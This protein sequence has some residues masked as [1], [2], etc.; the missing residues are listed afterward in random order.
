[1]SQ[2]TEQRTT[3]GRA[4]K[5]KTFLFMIAFLA[6]GIWGAWDAMRVYPKRGRIYSEFML[7]NYL[8][9]A[10]AQ[11]KL[12]SA[13]VEDPAG[14]LRALSESDARSPLEEA[15]YQWLSAL[16]RVANLPAI[17]RENKK[18]LAARARGAL[19]PATPTMFSDPSAKLKEIAQLNATRNQPAPLNDYDIPLQYAFMFAGAAGFVAMVVF[20]VRVKSKTYRYDPAAKRLTVPRGRSFTP[21]DIQTV[22]K[23]KWDKFLVFVTLKDGSPEQRLDLY[24]YHP[25][26]EWI[27]EMEKLS[28]EHEPVLEEGEATLCVNVLDGMPLRLIPDAETKLPTTDE[29]GR[30]SIYP[31]VKT[32]A[33]EWFVVGAPQRARL[34]EAVQKGE[35]DREALRVDLE[36][37]A[38]RVAEHDPENIPERDLR[39]S[40]DLEEDEQQP[41]PTTGG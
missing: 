41:A 21:A 5:V 22:D 12:A 35:L 32:V 30:A 25:L 20:F 40:E 14:T 17:S 13:S 11:F 39:P 15:R 36:T 16:A 2:S 19:L 1:M 6:W 4:W 34:R 10:D 7:Q 31:A 38:V 37:F 26:E 9:Q 33:G 28:P 23:R 27:L 3:L 24:R 18:K 8:E 29:S